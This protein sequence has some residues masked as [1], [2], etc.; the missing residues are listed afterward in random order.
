MKQHRPSFHFIAHTHWDREWY[1]TFEQFRRRLVQLIDHLLDLLESDP[2]FRSFHLD[3][4]TI[5]LE[6]YLA[7][8]PGQGE[9]L[10]RLVRDG[11]ILVGPWYQQNDLFLTSAESTVRNLLEG[12]RLA[13]AWGGVMLIGYLPDH[14]GLIGQMPQ[15]FRQVGINNCVFGRGYDVSKH[16]SAHLQWQAPDG[17]SV[18][19]ILLTH[20]YNN[21]QRLPRDPITL[22][23]L[24]TILC[25]REAAAGSIPHYLMMNGVDH[26]EA[27]ED[28]PDVLEQLRASFG[29]TY[30]FI[31]DTLPGYVRIVQDA[32]EQPG[33]P[34]Y[35]TLVGELREREAYAILSGTL[36]SRV[37]LKQANMACHDLIEKWVEPLS[38]WCA[39]LDLDGYDVE[40][41]R[42]LWKLY[43]Q[44][45]PHDSI[46]GCGQDAMHE[47]MLDRFT[48]VAEVAQEIIDQKMSV[49]ARQITTDTFA[50][51]DQVLL[52]VNPAQLEQRAVLRSSVYFLAEDM[53]Q[54]FTIE[55][56][57]G[58]AM[59]YR[60][61]AVRPSRIQVLSPINLPGV[62]DVVRFEI[63]WQPL[64]LPLGYAAYRVRPHQTAVPVTDRDADSRT[65]E[66]EYLRVEVQANGALSLTDKRSGV[67]FEAIARFEDAADGGDLYVFTALAGAQPLIWN[68]PVEWISAHSNALYDE[69]CYRF[70]W[71]LPAGLDNSLAQRDQQSVPCW[72]TVRLRLE[73]GATQ[74]DLRVEF[75]NRARD[76]RLRM[77]FPLPRAAQSVRAG[78]QFDV[79]QR[80]WNAGSEWPRDSNGQPFWKWVAPAFGEAGLSVFARGLHEYEMLDQGKLL[81]LTLLRCVETIN[82]RDSV[83]LESDV[84]PKAQCP[85]THVFELAL[86]PFAGELST[87]L[88]QEAERW[89]QGIRAAVAPVADTRWEQG[90]AWVQD[91]QL[92][93]TY[94]RPD[95]NHHKPRLP[96][97]GS[98]CRIDGPVMLSALKWAENGHAAI[99][100]LFNVEQRDATGHVALPVPLER[101]QRTNLLEEPQQELTAAQ[102]GFAAD[103]AAKQIAT[104][105]IQI[106]HNCE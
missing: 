9:R 79:L 41:S 45:H 99:V 92:P 19:G 12:F 27:Q 51:G 23:R 67:E 103:L 60:I 59:P 33:A 39:L 87:Q 93:A 71:Q 77:L 42:Y 43:M 13:R 106:A 100:R 44:N 86:R 65:L 3:G 73:R 63:E 72:C 58:A 82:Q 6:D 32:M 95:P 76:H 16:G 20:W 17:S 29:N 78:G 53:V 94:T 61:V 14:F 49:L 75:E 89:H 105:A 83:P 30:D 24:W 18:T 10:A 50:S 40:Y 25:E 48:S 36:S 102:T 31:H 28:L 96:L 21:A 90:R 11:R 84:Q 66:N 64:V 85:G 88:Y 4:Q 91:T 1:L 101:V 97:S 74:L 80:A 54:D 104:Y 22:E 46:C 26:L 47:H 7:I 34:A 2:R 57:T 8:R 98:F 5:V 55:D 69:C 70:T 68:D 35:P 62:L 52:V 81:A 15:I 37:Y 56:A 38:T